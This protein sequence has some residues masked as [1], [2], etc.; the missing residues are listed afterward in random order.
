MDSHTIR[1]ALAFGSALCLWSR[2]IGT[3]GNPEEQNGSKRR[4]DCVEEKLQPIWQR[5]VRCHGVANEYL[6]DS[7]RNNCDGEKCKLLIVA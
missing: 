3:F 4:R 5:L 6:A 2:V 1:A 7:D